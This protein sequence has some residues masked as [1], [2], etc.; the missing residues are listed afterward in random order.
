MVEITR[1]NAPAIGQA[2]V[3]RLFERVRPKRMTSTSSLFDA[4]YEQAKR[5]FYDALKAEIGVEPGEHSEVNTK[6]ADLAVSPAEATAR[7]SGQSRKAWW[8]L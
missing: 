6:L 8:Q 3:N 1:V 7:K 5:D 2:G 4:G